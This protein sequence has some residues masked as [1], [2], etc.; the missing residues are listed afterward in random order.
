MTETKVPV[1]TGPA[2]GHAGRVDAP[3]TTQLATS[4]DGTRIALERRG[5]GPALVMVEGALCHRG[6]GGYEEVAPLLADRFTV[7]G[8]DRR[9]RGESGAGASPYAPQ[10]EVEDLLAVVAAAGEGA[11]VFGMSS[12]A[13]LCLEAARQSPLTPRLAVYEPPFVLDDGHPADDPTLNARL[14]ELVAR[15]RTTRATQ[16]FLRCMGVPAPVTLV[17]PLLPVWKRMTAAAGTLPHDVEIV[18]PYRRGEPLPEGHYGAVTAGTLLLTGG[19]S[20]AHM[21]HAAEQ[22]A[23]QVPGART[24]VLAGQTHEVAA[25][26]LAPV[27][28]D[29]FLAA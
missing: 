16:L 6:M 4:A 15:G 20:P 24:A 3:P 29:Y 12:G 22:I 17:M 26:V 11:L 18:S 19:D 9:G 23:A 27:L 7:V 8:Y 21:R 28:A 13:A 14:R 2:G 10:R 1:T 5:T 25:D